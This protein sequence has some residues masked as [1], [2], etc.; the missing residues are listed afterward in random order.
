M[1]DLNIE[2]TIAAVRSSVSKAEHSTEVRARREE[3]GADDWFH[4]YQVAQSLAVAFEQ[5][6]VLAD[7]LGLR[8]TY[9]E[10]RKCRNEA[11]KYSDGLSTFDTDPDGEVHLRAAGGLRRLV[12]SLEA[13]YGLSSR[14]VSKDLVEVL[15]ASEYAITDPSCFPHPPAS[16]A[17]VHHRIEAVLKCVFPKLQTNPPI[18]KPIKNFKPDT[19]LPSVRTLVEY[20]FV[21]SKDDL[22]RVA[23]EILADTRGYIS[24][25][26]DNFIF[27][28]YETRR[29]KGEKDW[30]DLLRE[31]GTAWHTRAVV[32]RGE[33][34]PDVSKKTRTPRKTGGKGGASY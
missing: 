25:D 14:V 10:I 26:W 22:S 33:P 30:N 16:E 32:I 28:I 20:K 27:V 34:A 6:M 8:G 18:P 21:Q 23:D 5:L 19:G 29:L 2:S 9:R 11:L 4:E 13:A 1:R 31:C 3:G 15:Q 17:D 24:R 7:G 12:S